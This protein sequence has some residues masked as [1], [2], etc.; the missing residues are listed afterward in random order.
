MA[1][2]SRERWDVAIGEHN[3]ILAALGARDAK[4]LKAL[5]SDHLAHKLA[6]VLAELGRPQAKQAA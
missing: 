2:L 1:N 3:E 5:L 4:R 6:S